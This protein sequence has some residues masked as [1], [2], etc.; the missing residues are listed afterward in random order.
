[1]LWYNKLYL[2]I[3]FRLWTHFLQLQYIAEFPPIGNFLKLY[4]AALHDTEFWHGFPVNFHHIMH[5]KNAFISAAT[6]DSTV[7]CSWASLLK[8]A[9]GKSSLAS[10]TVQNCLTHPCLP[11]R[12][13]KMPIRVIA[14]AFAHW[15]MY[16]D[17]QRTQT[18]PHH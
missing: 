4:C 16:Y 12:L 2:I 15:V 14:L 17:S 3:Y 8:C 6:I 9:Y 5:S 1:M 10:I 7:G 13:V 18:L 11:A